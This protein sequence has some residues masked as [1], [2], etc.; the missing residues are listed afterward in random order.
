MVILHSIDPHD[1]VDAP[2]L[3][4]EID[5]SGR[6]VVRDLYRDL[7]CP[8]CGKIDERKAL[9]KGLPLGIR[10]TSKRPYLHS[11]EFIKMVDD[12]GRAIFT[13]LF[14][15]NIQ[16]FEIPSSGYWAV[17]ATCPVVPSEG[18]LGYRFLKKCKNCG[19]FRDLIFDRT[20]QRPLLR[21][22]HD[23]ISLSLESRLGVI[24]SWYVSQG[25]AHRLEAVSPPLT[26]LVVRP[27]EF[28]AE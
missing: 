27:K 26:G 24:D 8:T 11:R 2:L 6:L 9:N 7:S 19:R 17:R 10:I 21:L 28:S 12:R 20:V 18:D 22:G 4:R 25:Y 3:F 1:T 13:D 16:F 15:G 23:F 5:S 14:G